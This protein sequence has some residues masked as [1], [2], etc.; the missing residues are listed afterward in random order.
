[1]ALPPLPAPTVQLATKDG[2][3]SQSYAQYLAQLDAMARSGDFPALSVG[4]NA[5]LSVAGNQTLVGGFNEQTFDLGTVAG[6][7][8]TPR[9]SD[10]L[11]QKL[12]N[13]GAFTLAASTQ[14]GDLELLITNGAAA[15]AITF[16]GFSKSW[17]GDSLDTTGDHQFVVFIYGFAGG[18][19]AYL[20][21][22]LQ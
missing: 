15:G 1:M 16:L 20:I 12:L 9:P 7:T 3:V 19:S 21:K 2:Q 10:N 22:A 11:K 6:G 13:N 18:A 5:V 17:A 4:G 8:V 14:V